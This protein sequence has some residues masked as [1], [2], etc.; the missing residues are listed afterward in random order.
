MDNVIIQHKNEFGETPSVVVEVPGACTLL[1]CYADACKGW[2]LEGTGE[3]LLYVAISLRDDQLVRLSNATLNDH[4]RFVL[5]N[6]KFRKE[7][8]WGNYIKGV[9]AILS[10][11]G[12]SFSG[13][14]VTVEGPLLLSD[15]QMISTS[16][17]LGVCL[18]LDTLLDLK[19]SIPSIIRIA[20]QANT[21]FNNE[22]CKISDLLTIINGSRGK[23]LFFDLQHV[24]F[25]EIDF[26]FSDTN[27]EYIALIVD[28]KISPNAMREEINLKRKAT[29]I[30][31]SKLKE[32]KPGGF[33]RDFPESEL[34]AR[35]IPLDEDFRHICEYVLMESRLT[36]DAA[37]LLSQ[38]EAILYGK[39]MNRVQSG[40]RDLFE[41]TC[42]EVD[43]LTKRASETSGCLGSVLI[44]NGFS[45]NVMVLLSKQSLP[46]YI[47]RLE[48]Y[49]HIFGFH[50]RWYIFQSG[51]CA[52]V[53]FSD[54]T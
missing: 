20:Y 13:L 1:G 7:D 48:E 16:L 8:R 49:E 29:N 9:V 32:F 52:K 36:N 53:V 43:W 42:P 41:V 23:V 18:A 21:V 38:K 11:E 47:N 37:T 27:E 3:S 4:K 28:S 51:G 33:I 46:S 30:A 14:N 50:P 40:L 24:T 26:P 35:I 54:N 2:A 19:L 10:N 12:V 15:N 25:Q 17:A 39:T 34:S 5:G 31:F 6:I 44:C 45:G 22:I